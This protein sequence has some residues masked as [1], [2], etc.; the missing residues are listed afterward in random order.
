MAELINISVCLSDIPKDRIKRADSNGKCYAN[1]CVAAR[2]EADKYGNTHTVYMQQTKEE[3]N[4]KADRIFIGQGKEIIFAPV[5][6]PEAV[7]Q[8][9]PAPAQAIDDL[10]F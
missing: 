10:P 6:T 7:E 3:R 5:N 1:I 8:M 2:R 9:A 4:A